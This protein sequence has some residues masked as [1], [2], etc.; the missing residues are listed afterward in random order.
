MSRTR[1][2]EAERRMLR[3]ECDWCGNRPGDWCCAPDRS[4][5]VRFT[6]Y[7]HA[8]RFEQAT[9]AGLLPLD[10]LPFGGTA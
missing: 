10:L 8:S 4:G 2:S 6:Q 9:A 3:F 5:V 1:Q 7:L